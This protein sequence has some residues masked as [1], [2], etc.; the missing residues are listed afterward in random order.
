VGADLRLS[1]EFTSVAEHLEDDPAL[2]SIVVTSRL[3]QY[4]Q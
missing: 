4:Q 3:E 1:V 2:A